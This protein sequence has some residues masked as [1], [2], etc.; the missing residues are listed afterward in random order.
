M[1]DRPLPSLT[2]RFEPGHLP[3]K[4]SSMVI[5]FRHYLTGDMKMIKKILLGLGL[6]IAAIVGLALFQPDDFR[7]ERSLSMGAPIEVIFEQ[8]NDLHKWQTWSPWAKLDP[9]AKVTFSGPPSGQ[10]ASYTW[11]GNRQVGV[12]QMTIAQSTAPTR[13]QLDLEFFEP[14]AAKSTPIHLEARW[15]P[16][17]RHLGDVG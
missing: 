17:Q 14:F 10:G 5:A 3:T 9:Q 1:L 8:I 4:V 11:A 7:T 16:N 15:P 6:I 12:G 13:V 2:D